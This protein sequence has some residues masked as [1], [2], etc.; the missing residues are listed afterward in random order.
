M[1][2]PIAAPV[3]LAGEAGRKLLH[4]SAGTLRDE[5]RE[6]CSEI[7]NSALTAACYR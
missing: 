4:S 6:H 3:V 2:Q 1:I 7:E 5:L